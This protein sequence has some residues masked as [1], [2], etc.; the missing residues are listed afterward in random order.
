[1][2]LFHVT[3]FFTHLFCFIVIYKKVHFAFRFFGIAW[4]LFFLH[5]EMFFIVWAIMDTLAKTN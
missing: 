5:C 4:T 2:I 1:M 3:L